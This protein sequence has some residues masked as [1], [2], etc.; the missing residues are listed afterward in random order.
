MTS[1]EEH[2]II[3]TLEG[4]ATPNITDAWDHE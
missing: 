1:D 3:E 4:G 2:E